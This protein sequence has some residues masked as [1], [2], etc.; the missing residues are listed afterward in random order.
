MDQLKQKCINKTESCSNFIYDY[1]LDFDYDY[2]Y[3][4]A[5]SIISLVI[6]AIGIVLNLISS[7]IFTFSNNMKTRFFHFVRYKCYGSLVMNLCDVTFF[8]SF[9]LYNRF[10]IGWLIPNRSNESY[11]SAFFYAFINM[12]IYLMMNA[13]TSYLDICL[14]YERIQIYKKNIKLF[15]NQKPITIMFFLFTFSAILTLPNLLSTEI[16]EFRIN[17]T[18]RM[19]DL[20]KVN[21]L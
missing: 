13:F 9:F 11:K 17:R 7:I 2:D 1:K 18:D 12:T 4:L 5:V 19:N 15:K 14:V 21:I 16:T 6:S 3:V 10:N 20:S 8:F